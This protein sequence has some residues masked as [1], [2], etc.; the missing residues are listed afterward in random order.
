MNRVVICKK[1]GEVTNEEEYYK[2]EKYFK[3]SKECEKE[4]AYPSHGS[5]LKRL[6]L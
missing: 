1:C 5:S 4:A 3:K 2:E 6:F